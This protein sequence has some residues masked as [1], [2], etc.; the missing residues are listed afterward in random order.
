MIKILGWKTHGK[1]LKN[2]KYQTHG[3]DY[4]RIINPLQHLDKEKFEVTITDDPFND[5]LKTWDEITKY[6][7][8]VYFS[9]MDGI[10]DFV[11]LGLMSEKNNCE[12]VVDLDDA[13]DMVPKGSNVYQAFHP[14]SEQLYIC[15]CIIQEVK[16]VTTTNM[17]LKRH[18][19]EWL[20]LAHNKVKCLPN[21]ID[22]NMYDYKKINKKKSDKIVIQF[23]GTSTH[24]VDILWA[25][26]MVAMERIMSEYKNV[27]FDTCGM[28]LPHLKSRWGYRYTFHLGKPDVY[29]WADKLWPELMS[30]ADICLAPLQPTDFSK[31]KSGIKFLEVSAGKCPLIAS[32]IRQ[33]QEMEGCLLADPTPE[34]W[35][36][37]LKTLIDSPEKRKELG[38]QAYEYVKKYHQIQDN[39]QQYEDYFTTIFNN[40]PRNVV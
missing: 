7:D 40:S 33:Y 5:K 16:H 22:F 12:L 9:Y 35:Y 14:G 28:F 4:A 38:E 19:V 17:F 37:H 39:I 18:M 21:Y 24:V 10:I 3:V 6:Y 26:L 30:E 34:D 20:G 13:L 11:N 36:R 32:N 23:F 1:W 8:I 31:C 15:E 25:P 29:E 27:Y 2:D